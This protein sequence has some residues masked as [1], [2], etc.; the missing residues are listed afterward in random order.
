MV[1]HLLIIVR[2][3]PRLHAWRQCLRKN[4]SGA[5]GV[6]E[7]RSGSRTGS[8]RT[9]RTPANQSQRMNP[10]LRNGV[11]SFWTSPNQPRNTNHKPRTPNT[12]AE[13]HVAIYR[14]PSVGRGLGET[15]VTV[16][17]DW[18][19]FP[20]A[21]PFWAGFRLGPEPAPSTR[22][23]KVNGGEATIACETFVEAEKLELR[24]PVS[25]SQGASSQRVG[26][27]S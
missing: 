13:D 25:A 17:P 22:V 27:G 4:P 24:D 11:V 18:T 19:G 9:P 8:R 1:R 7:G 12:L 20:R 21:C 3:G 14:C 10:S 15:H 23:R 26:G 16:C 6:P 2:L 5:V